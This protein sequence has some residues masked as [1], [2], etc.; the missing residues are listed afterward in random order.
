MKHLIH[1]IVVLSCILHFTLAGAQATD[2]L[3]SWNDGPTKVSILAFVQAVT[4]AKSPDFVAV[5]ER[6]ATFDNDGTLWVEQPMYAQ[7]AFA[8]ERVRILA[9]RHPEWT[10][11][12]P[13]QS[14]LKGELLPVFEGGEKALLQ[15]LMASHAGSTTVDFERAVA[16]WIADTKAPRW[17]RPY[18]DLVYQPMLE[19][20]A[21]LRANEFKTYIVSGGVVEFMRPWAEKAYGIPPEQVIGSSIKT[22][23]QMRDGKPVLVR[24]PEIEF[25]TDKGGK[26]VAIN[27]HIGRRPIAAFGN[28]D[29]DLEML[30]WTTAGSGRRLG[31]LVHHTD[32]EREYAYDRTSKIGS[33]ETALEAAPANGWVVADMKQDWKVIFPF[34]KK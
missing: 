20:L 26:P 13:F 1:A 10:S 28:S 27:S 12:E 15:L 34:D 19:L 2:P 8:I 33:L 25:I 29:S 31:L 6:I 14:V 9:P 30:Q 22:E 23:F 5:P 32:A 17:S 16:A 4:D 7:M 21:Y 18:T 24:M 3:P 11:Q